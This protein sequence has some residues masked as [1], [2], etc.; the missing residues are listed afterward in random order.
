MRFSPQSLTVPSPARF[1]AR[2]SSAD[3]VAGTSRRPREQTFADGRLRVRVRAQIDVTT[4]L[5]P[6]A[7][8]QEKGWSGVNDNVGTEFDRHK[9][10][11]LLPNQVVEVG[12]AYSPHRHHK[13]KRH[14]RSG[15]RRN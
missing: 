5:R 7:T 12:N 3:A 2:N 9:Y 15:C 11:V 8:N 1:S 6:E 10:R 4:W 13:R 14:I